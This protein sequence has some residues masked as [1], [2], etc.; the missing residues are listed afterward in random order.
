MENYKGLQNRFWLRNHAEMV[1]D[2]LPLE[3]PFQPASSFRFFNTFE[4]FLM[5]LP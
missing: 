2:V 5:H 3:F 4:A 1:L